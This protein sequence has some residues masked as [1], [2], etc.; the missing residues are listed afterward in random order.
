MVQK[1]DEMKCDMCGKDCKAWSKD[2]LHFGE[3]RF[4]PTCYKNRK[5]R[6]MKWYD[7][8]YPQMKEEWGEHRIMARLNS[9]F[10]LPKNKQDK[11]GMMVLPY[12]AYIVM[13]EKPMKFNN[14]MDNFKRKHAIRCYK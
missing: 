2:I 1:T 12:W 5:W 11:E 13:M 7:K 9:H 3:K 14:E 6:E 10:T 8:P 4:C